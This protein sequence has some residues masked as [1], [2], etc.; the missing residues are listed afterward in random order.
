LNKEVKNITCNIKEDT[1][2]GRRKEKPTT[3]N[4]HY[5]DHQNNTT[6]KMQS[7]FEIVANNERTLTHEQNMDLVS[8]ESYPTGRSNRSKEPVTPH[9]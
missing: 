9:N 7:S 6:L 4:N 2:D 1:D 5:F 3:R 8:K